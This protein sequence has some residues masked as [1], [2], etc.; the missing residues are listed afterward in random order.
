MDITVK[1]NRKNFFGLEDYTEDIEQNANF[2][3][4]KKSIFSIEKRS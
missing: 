2:N 1:Y 3:D 4:L